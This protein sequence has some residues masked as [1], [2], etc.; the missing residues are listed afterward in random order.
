MDSLQHG[1]PIPNAPPWPTLPIICAHCQQ[2][3][4]EPNAYGILGR[5]CYH[6]GAC[7]EAVSGQ[8]AGIHGEG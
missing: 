5:G 7:W 6:A 4:T 2:P 1:T 3:I 8:P